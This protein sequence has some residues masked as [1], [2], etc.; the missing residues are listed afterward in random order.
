MKLL[1]I[2]ALFA[3][4]PAQANN[5]GIFDGTILNLD[6]FKKVTFNDKA[7]NEDDRERLMKRCQ[8]EIGLAQTALRTRSFTIYRLVPCQADGPDKSGVFTIRG[9]V[10]FL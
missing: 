3:A 10:F 8:D 2:L 7:F 5:N 4:A 1:M 9:A 6:G